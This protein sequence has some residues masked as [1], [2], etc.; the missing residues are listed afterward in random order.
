MSK[1]I[2]RDKQTYFIERANSSVD[3][4][5]FKNKVQNT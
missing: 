2:N 4:Y 1:N 5:A 3:L